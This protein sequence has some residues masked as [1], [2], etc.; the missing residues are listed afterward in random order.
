MK[1]EDIHIEGVHFNLNSSI[2]HLTQRACEK[3][4]DHGLDIISLKIELIK[5]QHSKSHKKEFIAKGHLFFKGK[6][7]VISCS[8]DNITQSINLLVKKLDRTIRIKH[9]VQK[10]KRHLN[11]FK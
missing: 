2:K 8:S 6:S 9:R 1:I 7:V 3:L 4:L 11:I 10:F 5:D